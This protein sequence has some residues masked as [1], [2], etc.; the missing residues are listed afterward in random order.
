[1]NVKVNEE[2]LALSKAFS[3]QIISD[4]RKNSNRFAESF[5]LNKSLLENFDLDYLPIVAVVRV[6]A[7]GIQFDIENQ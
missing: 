4:A 2:T 1:M 6:L 7:Y 3:D 5:E